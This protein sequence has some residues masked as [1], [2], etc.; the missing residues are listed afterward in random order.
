MFVTFIEMSDLT[1]DLFLFSF[2]SLNFLL[3]ELDFD[4]VFAGLFFDLF[5]SLNFK[6]DPFD[7][8]L[9]N[10]AWKV[11][12]RVTAFDLKDRWADTVSEN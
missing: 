10:Q 7:F 8:T 9:L 11:V 2:F 5:V 4:D 12:F 6:F 1:K 3:E